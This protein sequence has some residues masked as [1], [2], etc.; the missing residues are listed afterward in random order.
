MCPW[1]YIGERRL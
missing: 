1:C